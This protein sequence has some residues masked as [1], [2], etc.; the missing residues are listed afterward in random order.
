MKGFIED[1][2]MEL[3]R[4]YPGWEK[5]TIWE[6]FE[7]SSARYPDR[8]FV[9]AESRESF[10]YEETRL[11]AV[12][13]AKGFLAMGVKSGDHVAVQIENCPEQIFVMLALNAIGAVRVPVNT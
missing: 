7:V 1:R 2:L 12:C 13:V 6:Y 4:L 11:W 3:S 8:E 9:G 10:T 5:K